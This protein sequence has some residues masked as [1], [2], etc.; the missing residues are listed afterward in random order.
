MTMIH[1]IN[2][3]KIMIEKYDNRVD[4][5]LMSEDFQNCENK[6]EDDGC[7]FCKVILNVSMWTNARMKRTGD[8]P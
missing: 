6:D 4:R 2:I 5:I 1:G 3:G 8:K 7:F